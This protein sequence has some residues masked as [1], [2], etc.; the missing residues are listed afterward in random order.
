MTADAQPGL[1]MVGLPRLTASV[2]GASVRYYAVSFR[3]PS[4]LDDSATRNLPAPTTGAAPHDALAYTEPLGW[5]SIQPVYTYD[6]QGTCTL[7][8][9]TENVTYRITMPQWT[10]PA[11]VPKILLDWWR[12][13]LAHIAWHEEQHVLIFQDY[14]LGVDPNGLGMRLAEHPCSAASQIID[15]WASDLGAAQAAFDA[16]EANW[17]AKFPYTGPWYWWR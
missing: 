7:K 6:A 3:N 1:A 11:R 8:G 5:S 15:K 17:S 4:E 13:V 9:L 14:L 12:K 2:A 16:S 10:S